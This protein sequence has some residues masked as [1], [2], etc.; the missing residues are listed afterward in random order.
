MSWAN[1]ADPFPETFNARYFFTRRNTFTFLSDYISERFVDLPKRKVVNSVDDKELIKLYL[2]RDE[3]AIK[4]T[5]ELYGS[6]LRRLAAGLLGNRSDTEECLNDTYFKVW[7]AIPPH[8]PE[9]LYAFCAVICRRTAMDILD[10]RTAQQRS[11]IVV[12]LTA[13]ME[14]CIPDSSA[15]TFDDGQLSKLLNEFI[16]KL[17]E[18][19]RAVFIRRYWFGE[20]AVSIAEKYGYSETKVRSMLFRTRKKLK[21][22]LEGKDV[23]L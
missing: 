21:K 5:E 19:K 2:R 11:A 3:Q 17:D 20:T 15:D 10:K 23:E 6:R 1:T 9:S 13:E 18:D 14:Q 22:Y 12:E 4:S 16:A 7:N 8:C